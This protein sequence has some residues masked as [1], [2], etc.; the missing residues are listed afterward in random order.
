MI[1]RFAAFGVCACA[2][3][4]LPPAGRA[5]GVSIAS[6]KDQ[7][8]YHYI[9]ERLKSEIILEG[10]L[11]PK[12]DASEGSLDNLARLDDPE[13]PTNVGLAQA[14]ALRSYLDVHPEFESDLIVLGDMGQE[15]ALLVV[16]AKSGVTSIADLKDERAGQLSVGDPGG[17]A[18]LIFAALVELDPDLAATEP[19]Y[20]PTLEA[21][22]EL[23]NAPALTKLRGGLI[24]QRPGRESPPVRVALD[25]PEVY[26]FVPIREAD[27]ASTSPRSLPDGSPVYSS[28]QVEIGHTRRKD[29]PV[30]QTVCTRALLLGARSKLDREDRD[31][32]AQIM[33]EKRAAIAGSAP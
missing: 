21:L 3:L 31:L 24:V 9:G 2:F 16:S 26:R 5:D 17:G 30:V 29:R 6:G 27:L 1:A 11:P 15:C 14:D 19:V 10:R 20:T 8:S 12:N 13:N 22:L 7:G 18:A 23:E 28:E 33:L 4:L 25:R 32:L